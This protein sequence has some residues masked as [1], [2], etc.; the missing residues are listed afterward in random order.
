MAG[1][2]SL[3]S[4][5]GKTMEIELSQPRTRGLTV[6]VPVVNGPG[7]TY[8]ERRIGGALKVVGCLFVVYGVKA[9]L[10][11]ALVVDQRLAFRLSAAVIGFC[12]FDGIR[13]ALQRRAARRVGRQA[14][15]Q[16]G[17]IGFRGIGASEESRA[18]EAPQQRRCRSLRGRIGF[19]TEE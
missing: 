15:N 8:R 7:L 13:V 16:R 19:V 9:L 17:R 5:I 3:I 14:T 12:L 10:D 11:V 6:P 18:L 4:L 2:F 1:S